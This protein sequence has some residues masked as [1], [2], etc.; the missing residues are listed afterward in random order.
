MNEEVQQAITNYMWA[1]DE[2]NKALS[3][4]RGVAEFIEETE[5]TAQTWTER[6]EG[7][8]LIHC[9]ADGDNFPYVL[10]E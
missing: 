7:F 3:E 2:A 4:L 1:I 5:G 8:E 6:Y 9:I 10:E